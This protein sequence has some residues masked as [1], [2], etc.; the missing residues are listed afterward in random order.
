[1]QVQAVICFGEHGGD[2]NPAF[3]I[4]GDRSSEAERQAFTRARNTT[5]VFLD[6]ADG[7]DLACSLD[8]FYPHAR[9]PLCLHATLAAAYVLFARQRTQAC[10]TVETALRGQRLLLSRDGSDFFVQLARHAAP[11]VDIAPDLAARLLDAPAIALASSPVVASIGSPKLLIEVNDTAS[12]HAL[13]PN[14]GLVTEWSK[15][16]GVSG[17]YVYCRLGDGRYEGRNFNHLD[18][19]LEDSATGVAAGALTAVLGHGITLLQGRATGRSCLI[20]S[21]IAGDAILVGGRG[22]PA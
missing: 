15:A 13:R 20:R 12:L 11:P 1:M 3:V 22:E 17:C 10:L 14:L 2:G 19:A 9:S 4:E 7:A 16:Y 8:Y 18:P 5:C 21:A 6:P